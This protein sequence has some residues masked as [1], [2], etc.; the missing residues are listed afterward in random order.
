MARRRRDPT[1]LELSIA[2]ARDGAMSE[3]IL[4]M[5]LVGSTVIVPSSTEPLNSATEIRPA[6]L[7]NPTGK[8][9]A[10]FTHADQ[11]GGIPSS[12]RYQVEIDMPVLLELI[13]PDVGLTINQGSMSL[14]LDMAP[15][16]VQAL[17]K[18]FSTPVSES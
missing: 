6:L 11:V 2:H 9:L 1:P 3:G 17:R 13:P 5:V 7:P 14:N 15:V 16:S 10:V 8:R 18:L 12:A 4:M